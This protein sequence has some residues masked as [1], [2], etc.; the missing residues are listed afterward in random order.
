MGHCNLNN[1]GVI[2]IQKFQI[3]SRMGAAWTGSGGTDKMKQKQ[4]V[5]TCAW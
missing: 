3:S 1:K 5:F 4:K 2:Y